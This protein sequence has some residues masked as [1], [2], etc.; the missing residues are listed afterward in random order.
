MGYSS[1]K[2]RVFFHPLNFLV[3]YGNDSPYWMDYQ[4][5]THLL[6]ILYFLRRSMGSYLSTRG[7]NLSDGHAFTQATVLA[8]N[9]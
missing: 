3:S 4:R 5:C 8:W 7:S 6:P 1:K 9:L 2:S